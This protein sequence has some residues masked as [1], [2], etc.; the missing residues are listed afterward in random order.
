MLHTRT[1]RKKNSRLSSLLSLLPLPS[2]SRLR[3]RKESTVPRA[4]A[5][6][7]WGV[8]FL[9]RSLRRLERRG[10]PAPCPWSVHS[11]VRVSGAGVQLREAAALRIRFLRPY[12]LLGGVFDGGEGLG[13]V[14]S[15]RS[16]GSGE[17]VPVVD[18]GVVEAPVSCW[19]FVPGLLLYRGGAGVSSGVTGKLLGFF[20]RPVCPGFFPVQGSGFVGGRSAEGSPIL[21]CLRL[22]LGLRAPRPKFVHRLKLRRSTADYTCSLKASW[23]SSVQGCGAPI[24]LFSA[25]VASGRGWWCVVWRFSCLA[26]ALVRFRRCVPV[27]VLH[28]CFVLPL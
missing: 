23:C 12:P 25:G 24:D 16:V 9:F 6:G 26:V 3:R 21:R 11:R 22:D 28:P 10:T 19:A 2:V 8:L 27:C 4:A 17:L 1:N 14:V 5:G 20:R 15:R 18:V 7:C 13:G